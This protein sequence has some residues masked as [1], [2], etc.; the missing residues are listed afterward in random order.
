MAV[1][2]AFH[3]EKAKSSNLFEGLT[4][5]AR[6]FDLDGGN[7]ALVIGFLFSRD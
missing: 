7:I 1:S 6:M 4:F 5:K 2:E 3:L